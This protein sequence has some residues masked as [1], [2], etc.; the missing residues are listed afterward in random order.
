MNVKI[1]LK[2]LGLEMFIVIDYIKNDARNCKEIKIEIMILMLNESP[3]AID[4]RL[5]KHGTRRPRSGDV[6]WHPLCRELASRH[7][8]RPPW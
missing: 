2:T 3:S 4:S 5:V 8:K 6:T 1:R 7:A